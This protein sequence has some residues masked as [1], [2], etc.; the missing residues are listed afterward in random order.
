MIGGGQVIK[1]Q[2]GKK[3]RKK[4]ERRNIDKSFF[5]LFA[6]RKRKKNY[7]EVFF[8]NESFW[9]TS[10]SIGGRSL[11]AEKDTLSTGKE[12]THPHI[13]ESLNSEQPSDKGIYAHNILQPGKLFLFEPDPKTRSTLKKLEILSNSKRQHKLK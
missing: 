1:G 5:L 7:I 12:Y 6:I 4:G 10:I 9:V 3:E 8:K 2:I 13:G 11:Y